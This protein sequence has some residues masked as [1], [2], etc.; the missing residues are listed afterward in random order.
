MSIGKMKIAAEIGLVLVLA[1]GAAAWAGDEF[2]LGGM[3]VPAGTMASGTLAVP[4]G[5]D[6]GATEIPCTV[7]AGAKTGPV[8][9]LV[10]GLHAYEYPPILALYRLQTKID[11]QALRGTVIMV[12]IANLPSFKKRTIYYGPDDWKNLNRVFP[13]DRKGTM[14]Q[15]IAAVLTDEVIGRAD[16]VI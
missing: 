3:R 15:R 16:A 1:L 7:I 8:L 13:G 14:S 6:G 11:P 2:V 10:A 4:A 5:P 9:A 12:H